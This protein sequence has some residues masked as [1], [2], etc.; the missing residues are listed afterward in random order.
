MPIEV[1][2][3]LKP[4]FATWLGE[5]KK[6]FAAASPGNDVAA[7]ATV[8]AAAAAGASGRSDQKPAG[9]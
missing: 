2:A 5:A 4:D 7:G 8:V 3:L 9:N 1:K 6:K